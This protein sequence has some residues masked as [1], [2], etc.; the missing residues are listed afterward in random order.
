MRTWYEQRTAELEEAD[1]DYRDWAHATEGARR[2]AVA[3]DAELRRR[4]PGLALAPRR[5]AEPAP[6]TEAEH[7]QLRH[8]REAPGWMAARSGTC[9][10]GSGASP[11][12]VTPVA[13]RAQAAI[14][15]TAATSSAR[16]RREAC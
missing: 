10:P 7:A 2:L 6:A 8:G 4:E 12:I 16:R 9:S 14:I 11:P 5:T 3:A 1:Q 15:R 13:A